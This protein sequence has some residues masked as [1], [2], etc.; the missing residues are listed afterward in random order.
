[1]IVDLSHAEETTALQAMSLSRAPVIFSHSGARARAD[2]ARNLSDR[3]LRALRADGGIVMVPLAP[4]L[5]TT[6]HWRWWSSGEA[7]YAELVAAH[8]DGHSAV[9]TGMTAWDAANPEPEVTVAHVADQIEHVARVA[10]HEHVGIGSDFDGMGR[11]AIPALADASRLPSLFAE[12]ARRGWTDAHLHAL[13]SGNFERVLGDV[14][15]AS[16]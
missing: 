9:S 11:F 13:A 12:L 4:Y 14:E 16:E 5:T 8:G 15:A 3:A 1:M 2:T 10:G 7:R 6:A